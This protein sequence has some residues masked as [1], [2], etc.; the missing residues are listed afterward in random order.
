MKN[1][2]KNTILVAVMVVLGVFLVGCGKDNVQPEFRDSFTFRFNLANGYLTHTILRDFYLNKGYEGE[3]YRKSVSSLAS[4]EINDY[5]RFPNRFYSLEF[6]HLKN[7]DR[8]S[9]ANSSISS[10][11]FQRLQ[12]E[13]GNVRQYLKI[14]DFEIVAETES[15]IHYRLVADDLVK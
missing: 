5:V 2:I 1:S 13:N 9:L 7:T 15:Y 3:F 8:V 6:K 4:S 14:E 12:Y 11:H 10:D